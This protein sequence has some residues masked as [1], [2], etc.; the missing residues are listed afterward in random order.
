MTRNEQFVRRRQVRELDDVVVGVHLRWYLA[1]SIFS[2]ALRKGVPKEKVVFL[3]IHADS[4][5]PSLRGAMAYV[6]AERYVT[7]SYRKTERVYLARAEVREHPVVRHSEEESLE[8]EGLSRELAESIVDSFETHHLNVHP[9]NPV[10]DSVVRDGRE[11]VPAIIR[12]NLVPTRL[13]L[14]VCNLGNRYDRELI[15]TRSTAARWP[16][17][18]RG[19]REFLRGSA[20]GRPRLLRA[21]NNSSVRRLAADCDNPCAA[22]SSFEVQMKFRAIPM[23][24]F[25]LN[26]N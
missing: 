20:R 11:W 15:K 24:F 21:R 25:I 10:R 12:Y 4:L 9:F 14:E 13:L 2:R 16:G 26:S 7:G 22:N 6:P 8:A 18:V 17:D 23:L 1:N 3:S 19:P 5:H